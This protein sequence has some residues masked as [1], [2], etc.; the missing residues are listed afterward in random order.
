MRIKSYN[1]EEEVAKLLEIREWFQ[2][3]EKKQKSKENKF[4]KLPEKSKYDMKR[5]K[6]N[7]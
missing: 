4:T 3:N 7:T 6:S 1:Y 5:H 2:F